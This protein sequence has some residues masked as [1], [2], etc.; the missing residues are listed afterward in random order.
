MSRGTS[1]PS[2]RELPEHPLCHP[3]IG[4][5]FQQRQRALGIGRAAFARD[6]HF[7]ER[8]GG[9]A[10]IGA[11]GF[12]EQRAGAHGVLL[13]DRQRQF[14]LGAVLVV[15]GLAQFFEYFDAA[16]P[17]VGLVRAWPAGFP[18]SPAGLASA[19]VL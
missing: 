1:L 9:A 18:A 13:T 19:R 14:G 4:R 3:A 6:Q 11:A 2:R 10:G 15:P 8:N 7:R 12:F 17:L 16:G 5:A